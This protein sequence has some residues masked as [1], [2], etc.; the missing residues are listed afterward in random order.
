MKSI[1]IISIMLFTTVSFAQ[2]PEA[3]VTDPNIKAKADGITRDYSKQLALTGTQI[4]L[5]KNK[6]AHFLVLED[7]ILN[8][9][10]GKEQLDAL[11]EMRA[12]QSLDM[13]DI[14]TLPQYRLYKKI[15][16]EIWPLRQI[17]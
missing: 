2:F 13:N 5:F 17:E 16:F 4:P 15:N 1:I 11:V 6:I 7:K 8:D 12:N 3:S 10:Q 9:L 14:L